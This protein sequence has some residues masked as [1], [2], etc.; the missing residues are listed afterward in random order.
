MCF[1]K[2]KPSHKKFRHWSFCH[3]IMVSLFRLFIA[4]IKR[5]H[6]LFAG[7][8]WVLPVIRIVSVEKPPSSSFLS[9]AERDLMAYASSS[10]RVTSRF[11]SELECVLTWLGSWLWIL[12]RS[13]PSPWVGPSLWWRSHRSNNAWVLWVQYCSRCGL[14]KEKVFLFSAGGGLKEMHDIIV[15]HSSDL[16]LENQLH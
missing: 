8:V 7:E 3:R 10:V 1:N 11:Q 14:W 12:H 4:Y 2:T 15:A 9:G 6:I 16:A 5:R 13:P